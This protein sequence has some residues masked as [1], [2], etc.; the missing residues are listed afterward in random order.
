MFFHDIIMIYY[1]NCTY[2][3]PKPK[4][5]SVLSWMVGHPSHPYYVQSHTLRSHPEP[6]PNP[7]FVFL[8]PPPSNLNPNPTQLIDAPDNGNG[9][10]P[11]EMY[12]FSCPFLRTKKIWVTHSNQPRRDGLCHCSP[13]RCTSS[14]SGSGIKIWR[15]GVKSSH[16]IP[17]EASFLFPGTKMKNIIP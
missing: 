1:Y 7:Y 4:P 12:T 15:G 9:N 3:K 17:S 10:K 6:K 8:S 13:M 16:A 5:N 2:S 14:V 11:T